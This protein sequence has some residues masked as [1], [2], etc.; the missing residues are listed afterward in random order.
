[1]ANAFRYRRQILLARYTRARRERRRL[2]QDSR[3]FAGLERLQHHATILRRFRTGLLV[4]WA[5]L[6]L[7]LAASA[8]LEV[9]TASILFAIVVCVLLCPGCEMLF[10]PLSRD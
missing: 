6:Q 7:F 2:R 9:L 4:L 1:M 5:A 10:P 3:R 8:C